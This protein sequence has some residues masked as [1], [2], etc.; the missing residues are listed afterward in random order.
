LDDTVGV[1]F[2]PQ[3]RSTAVDRPR[4]FAAAVLAAV[5]LL[6]VGP[7]SA[8]ADRYV[9][10]NGSD[11]AACTSAAPCATLDRAYRSAQPGETV[12][13]GAGSYPN[14]TVRVDSA[15]AAS[16]AAVVFRPLSGAAVTIHCIFAQGR[17]L[18][19]RDLTAGEWHAD[20]GATEVVFRNVTVTGGIFITSSSHISA[21][22]GSVGPG[23]DFSSEIKA[24]DGSTVAPSDVLIDGV[25]FHDWVRADPQAHVDCLH[26]M[27]VDGLTIRNS[28]FRNCEAFSVIFTVYGIAGPPRNVVVENNFFDC[29]RT[30]FYSLFLADGHGEYWRNFLIR[31]NSADKG[32]AVGPGTTDAN[33]NVV[34]DS[35]IAPGINT[36]CSWAGV[37]LRYN[38]L[39]A[40]PSCGGITA[41]VSFLDTLLGDLHLGAISSARRAGNPSSYPANDID[42]E[43]RAGAEAPDAGAD[44]FFVQ[45]P[46]VDPTPPPPDN[47][48]TDTGTPDPGAGSG[49]GQG[50]S[51]GPEGTSDPGTTTDGTPGDGSTQPPAA[52]TQPPGAS[53]Q[54]PG[55]STPIVRGVVPALRGSVLRAERS[56][57]RV[58]LSCA[59]RARRGCSGTV[60]IS[61][62]SGSSWT[63][64]ADF[65]VGVGTSKTLRVKLSPARVRVL[66]EQRRCRVRVQT[67]GSAAK[68]RTVRVARL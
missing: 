46:P 51:T 40:G 63:A 6:G 12:L 24:E 56:A 60:Q 31:Y 8:S 58:G 48:P 38:V 11:A 41:S 2:F 57:L 36:T 32:F 68:W 14:Q 34:F 10:T 22:G 39:A 62:V 9:A 13:I 19:F 54:P 30:G 26:V 35:N 67:S 3:V 1:T 66:V 28:R 64:S 59:K 45:P 4:V 65:T 25:L 20:P 61:P 18:E 49:D 52:P 43:S 23:T 55:A 29:C 17:K 16:T 27:T 33:S 5:L 15:K 37:T 47:P 21:I 50:E 44:E 7:R 42:G 53:T